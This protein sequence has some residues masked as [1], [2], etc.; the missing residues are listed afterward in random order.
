MYSKRPF[1]PLDWLDAMAIEKIRT[2]KVM[3]RFY[4]R[5]DIEWD[6]LRTDLL[7]PVCSVNK[8]FKLKYYLLDAIQRNHTTIKTS[9]GAWSNHIVATA[10]AARASKL[11]S[12]GMIRGEMP[13]Y[14]SDTLRE[15]EALGMTLEYVSRAAF[16][17]YENPLPG[18]YFI[19]SG[20]YGE[21]GA[22]GA[23]E[24]LN[25][26]AP[27]KYTHIICATGTGT[28]LAGLA[29]AAASGKVIGV[30]ILKYPG[31]GEEITHLTRNDQ[32]SLLPDFHG[33]GYA[34][35]TPELLQFM[36]DFYE[37]TDIPTDFVYTG[38]LM[39]AIFQLIHR[40]Y[41][42]EGSS[43][44]AIHSGGLQGNKSLKKGELVF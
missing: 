3:N 6:I 33:G 13:R 12:I 39:F 17:S 7:H 44:L 43:I 37:A 5:D 38:K 28:M 23:A 9:G 15:A 31:I 36:N 10:F 8:F 11:R 30:P 21:L 18:E 25:H 24:I 34:K 35:K 26:V 2:Q 14:K 41:F 4:D 22:K 16:P 20:G 29:Q 27:G 19:P 40:Q 42:P 1:E 32:Y